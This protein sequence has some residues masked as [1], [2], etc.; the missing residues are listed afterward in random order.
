MK[1]TVV[2]LVVAIVLALTGCSSPK[3]TTSI[4]TPGSQDTIVKQVEYSYNKDGKLTKYTL[5]Y[6]YTVES[7]GY[8]EDHYVSLLESFTQHV[9]SQNGLTHKYEV[10]NSIITE[11]MTLDPKVASITD[12]KRLGI[13]PQGSPDVLTGDALTEVFT[14]E[15][16]VCAVSE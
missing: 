1:K 10:K 4:C 6:E 16:L 5:N 11:E 7:T 13:L 15:G 9:A 14:K 3:D 2:L 12:A 8:E